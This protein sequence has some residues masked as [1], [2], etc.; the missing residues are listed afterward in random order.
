VRL[1][2][3]ERLTEDFERRV[4]RLRARSTA[5]RR[6]ALQ[7][8]LVFLAV[9]SA[10]FVLFFTGSLAGERRQEA[11]LPVVAEAQAGGPA[12]GLLGESLVSEEE[13]EEEPG[14]DAEALESRCSSLALGRG[15]RY[16]ATSSSWRPA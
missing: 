3:S 14:F 15:S 6:W 13:P 16:G 5:R 2:E 8:F 10:W 7:W 1:H 11:A 12:E 9:L 4:D